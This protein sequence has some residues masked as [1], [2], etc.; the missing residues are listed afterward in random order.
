MTHCHRYL[1]TDD[2]SGTHKFLRLLLKRQNSQGV[3]LT[4]YFSLVLK[5]IV[6]GSH[7]QSTKPFQGVTRIKHATKF[8]FEVRSKHKAFEAT[9]FLATVCTDNATLG[10]CL[11]PSDLTFCSLWWS[12]GALSCHIDFTQDFLLFSSKLL[13]ARRCDFYSFVWAEKYYTA[14][15]HR[16]RHKELAWITFKN[17]VCTSK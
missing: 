17:S 1:Y 7:I 10:R 15:V 5:T 11:K 14:V 8:S 2:S 13:P 3:K 4:A 6:L 9:S 12:A 16:T